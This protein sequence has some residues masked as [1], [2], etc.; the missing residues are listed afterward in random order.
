[1]S[2]DQLISTT[3]SVTEGSVFAAVIEATGQTSIVVDHGALLLTAE[4]VRSGPDLVLVGAD[5]TKIL[6]IGFFANE[7]PPNLFTLGGAEVSGHLASLLAGPAASGF[8]QTTGDLGNPIGVVED[9]EGSVFASRIDGSRVQLNAG[10]PVFQDDV[11]ETSDDGAIGLRFVDDTTFSIAEDARMVL[12]DFVYDPASNSGNAVVNVLQGSFSFVSGAVAKLGDDA[13]TVKTPVLTIGIRG[14]YVTGK[15]GQEGETTEIVNLPDDNG[16]VGSIFASNQGGGVLLNDAYEGTQTNSQFSAPTQPRVYDRQ[17]VEDKFDGALKFLPESDGVRGRDRGQRED[18]NDDRDGGASEDA[19]GESSDGEEAQ[20]GEGEAEAAEEEGEETGEAEE[21]EEEA[22]D[23]EG[24]AAETDSETLPPA[25]GSGTAKIKVTGIDAA[26]SAA[27]AKESADK[28]EAATKKAI[29]KAEGEGSGDSG[30]AS[31]GSDEVV[32]EEANEDEVEVGSENDDVINGTEGDDTIEGGGGGDTINGGG[33]ND[34]IAGGEGGDSLAGGAGNDSLDGGVGNDTLNG[35][36]GNDTLVGGD[37]TDTAD[38]SG[39][40]GGISVDLT[41]GTV[42]DGF[43]D[44]DAISG[45]E[46]ILGSGFGDSFVGDGGASTFDGGAGNDTLSGGNG[47][48]TLIGGAGDDLFIVGDA[49]AGAGGG[50]DDATVGVPDGALGVSAEPAA[51]RSAVVDDDVFLEGNFLSVGISGLGS[52]GTAN[53][54]PAGFNTAFNEN[55]LGMSIDQDGFGV[56]ADP[57]TA[58]FFLPG[59]PEEGFTVGYNRSGINFN[60][61]NA[62]RVG[63]SE[64]NQQNFANQS[65]GTNLQALWEGVSGSDGNR[66]EVDQTVRFNEDDKF[67][68]TTIQLTNV[69]ADTLNNVRYMRS[70]DPDQ[71]SGIPGG[72]STSTTINRIINQ[73]GDG[74]GDNLA[75]VSATGPT[76]GVPIFFLADDVRAR[77]STFGFSNRDVFANTL[78]DNPQAEGTLVTRDEAIV[79]NFDVGSLTAG[80]STTLTFFTSL[81]QNFESSIEAITG[82]DDTIVEA[83][84][85]GTDTIQSSIGITMAD[86][87]EILQLVGGGNVDGV[88]NASDNTITGTSGNNVLQGE[89]GNDFLN[90][91]SGNDSLVGGDGNDTLLGGLGVDNMSGNAGA[92]TFNYVAA[93]DGVVVALNQT[94]AGAGVSV[95]LI[96]DFASGTDRFLFEGVD[97]TTSNLTVIGASYD[98]TNSGLEAGESFIFDGTHLIHDTDVNAA[99]YTVV[100]QVNGDAVAAADVQLAAA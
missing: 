85:G 17:E 71:D 63:Q 96:N 23:G 60:F 28:F 61:T 30:D 95:D 69:G 16:E 66:L 36:Q 89:G 88:G 29:D 77:V 79:I 5:G 26:K 76:T 9:A 3:N 24:D 50:S 75:I 14:T 32:E 42:T 92:D 52:Y 93:A 86:N 18:G 49:G 100:A 74:G 90:G 65:S 98:G 46:V 45:V 82:G 10:D 40:V 6:L 44:T 8:A 2:R 59:S 47:A 87:V 64:L 37:G 68:E 54:A 53:S 31:T 4:Y 11:I 81:D 27:D 91:A 33:G 72:G 12:D 58:D 97:F 94:V 20:N 70:F 99:G 43:R 73:P 55:Q 38:F 56:G 1:M 62:E 48:D 51:V 15:G 13:L 83:A 80:Q 41:R 39:T 78:H 7:T 84:G 19:N 22:V 57:T 21:G 34:S 25:E 67:F 35:G